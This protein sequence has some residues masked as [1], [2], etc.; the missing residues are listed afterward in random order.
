LDN[1]LA[2][3]QSGDDNGK[4][5]GANRPGSDGKFF[6]K[7]NGAMVE[8]SDATP[9]GE[10]I[11]EKAA[12]KP[13]GEYVLIQLLR[14]STRSIGLDERVD[15][16]AEGA[17]EFRAFKSDRIFRFVL[18]GHG[19]EWGVGR[20]SEPELRDIGHVRDDEVL[21]LERD[22]H[23]VHLGPGDLLDL[24]Q[25]GTERVR[26]EK[27]LVTVYFENMPRE[28]KR[29]TYT[30]EQ[31]KELFGVEEGYVLEVINDEGTLVPLNPGE[32]TRVK[33]GMKFYQQV[34]CGGSS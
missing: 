21:V 11:L 4:S 24:S 3:T 7:V 6:T 25:R 9:R 18:N 32:K 19:F 10:R 27:R 33:D 26:T 8:F 31:L 34:P 15:L 30:T 29:G 5:R 20:I 2:A 28:I 17:E 23:D 22:G 16:S 1:S 14:N 12:L 13:V